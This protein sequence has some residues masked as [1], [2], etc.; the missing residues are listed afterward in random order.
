[1]LR[2]HSWS[3]QNFSTSSND[4]AS[5]SSVFPVTSRAARCRRVLLAFRL[6]RGR[7]GTLN[8]VR[9]FSWR[10]FPLQLLIF[11]KCFLLTPQENSI[12]FPASSGCPFGDIINVC[13]QPMNFY[14]SADSS[15]AKSLC[16]RTKKE[17]ACEC[18]TWKGEWWWGGGPAISNN[19][20]HAVRKVTVV[21]VQLLR[22]H[23]CE[24]GALLSIFFASFVFT[25]R[26]LL[27]LEIQ[28]PLP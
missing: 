19:S 22:V 3:L 16:K 9:M 21:E 7:S 14:S 8:E 11:L 4:V 18:K 5:C 23:G 17:L 13:P 10:S 6:A 1:M 20:F 27:S 28:A 25:R 15:M 26:V 2:W 12:P 24:H